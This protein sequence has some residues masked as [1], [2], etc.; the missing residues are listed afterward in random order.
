[1]YVHHSISGLFASLVTFWRL[2]NLNSVLKQ[3][4]WNVLSSGFSISLLFVVTLEVTT[5]TFKYCYI[6]LNT[7]YLS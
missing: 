1:M 2:A 3:Y 6:H 7:T 5:N 4:Q